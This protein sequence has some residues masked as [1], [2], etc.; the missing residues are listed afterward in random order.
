MVA[1][2]AAGGAV[3]RLDNRATPCALGLLRVQERLAAMPVGATLE[4][5]TRDRFAPYEV[6]AWVERA[7]LELTALE[8]RGFWLFGSTMFRIRKTTEVRAPRR[9][10]G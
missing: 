5:V 3:E 6:P 7:G 9:A 1:A 4:V 10:A 8:K 2:P